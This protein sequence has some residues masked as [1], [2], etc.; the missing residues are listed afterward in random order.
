MQNCKIENGGCGSCLKKRFSLLSD[1]SNKELDSLNSGRESISFN[2]GETIYNT[3]EDAKKLFCLNEGAVKISVEDDEGNIQIVDFK[4]KV[5]FLGF[6]EL[7]SEKEYSTSAT[8]INNVSICTIKKSDF[9]EIVK[10]NPDLSMKVI[11]NLS[12][13]LR[14]TEKRIIKLTKKQMR[15]RLAGAI[16]E[17]TDIYGYSKNDKRLIDIMIKRKELANFS[18]MTTANAIRTISAFKKENLI[19]IERRKIW[20]TDLKAL[21]KV[22]QEVN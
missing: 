14:A 8:A 19:R 18:N 7:M 9:F 16:L 11:K 13:S 20:I 2:K 1:L 22:H 5:D 12:E 4:K 6:H 3:G 15:A 21:K 17:L 10:N